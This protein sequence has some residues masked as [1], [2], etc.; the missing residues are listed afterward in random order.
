MAASTALALGIGANTMVFTVV[1]AILIR[2]PAP[3]TIR[4]GSWPSGRAAPKDSARRVSY[5]DYEGLAGPGRHP[6]RPFG[7]HQQQRQ[8]ERRRAGARARLRCL[9]LAQLLP[10]ARGAAG[11]RPGFRSRR[12]PGRRRAGRAP[13]VTASGRPATPGTPACSGGR[14]GSTRSPATVVGVMAPGMRFPNDADIWI[15]R[16]S[17][18]PESNVADRGTR[19]FGVI[20]RLGPGASVDQARQELR[21]IGARLAEAYPETNRDRAPDLLEF[22]EYVNGGEPALLTLTLMGAVAFVLLIACANVASLLLARAAGRRRETAVRVAMGATRLRIVRQLLIESLVLAIVAGAAGFLLSIL[23]IRWLSG[24][25]RSAAVG[26]PVLDRVHARWDRLRLHRGALPPDGGRVRPRAGAPGIRDG[27]QGDP[28]GGDARQ[29][30]RRPGTPLGGRTRGR[31]A[32]AEP[33]A[34]LR[35]RFS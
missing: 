1:N 18:P 27:C 7:L 15:P 26:M 30:G 5:P 33:R 22:L 21:A 13:S 28:E 10:T 19:S 6:C 35:R 2:K 25:T 17:L 9:R 32:R 4:T 16:M 3:S 14:S 23:G 12:R 34:P 20:G 24:V 31:A 8:R 11:S 29:P